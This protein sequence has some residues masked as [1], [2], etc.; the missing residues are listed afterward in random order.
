LRALRHEP[1]VLPLIDAHDPPIPSKRDRP[2]LAMPIAESLDRALRDA[3]MALIIEALAPIASTLARLA[4]VGTYHRDLKPSNLFRLGDTWCVGDFGLATFIGKPALTRASDTVGSVYYIA[5]EVLQD[6]T[7]AAPG[8][9]DVFSFA[10][11]VWV[12]CAHKRQPLQG[13]L[14]AANA[15]LRMFS[16]EPRAYRLDPILARCTRTDPAERPSMTD[17]ARELHAWLSV[18]STPES[19]VSLADLKQQVAAISAAAVGRLQER[20]DAVKGTRRILGV[21]RDRWLDKVNGD[22]AETV[23]PT[24]VAA[25]ARLLAE[26]LP[27]PVPG[28]LVHREAWLCTT[29][30]PVDDRVR[31]GTWVLVQAFRGGQAR[32]SALHVIGPAAASGIR[33]EAVIWRDT[34][35]FVMGGP[36][37]EESL[38]RVGRGLRQS[39]R[40]AVLV[41]VDCLE[42]PDRPIR[43]GI[44]GTRADRLH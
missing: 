13:Q 6:P 15:S 32:I 7:S 27:T 38:Q 28:E 23:G 37:E 39:V 4:A 10:K 22:F 20:D 33:P 25:D 18:S 29:A 41:L 2:W 26:W 31:L 8:P 35:T 44:P 3:P 11:T 42:N 1:G 24:R 14:D 30:A 16:P 12:L 43:P 9:A 36:A 5:P 40:D 19:A 21:L 34:A 17:V